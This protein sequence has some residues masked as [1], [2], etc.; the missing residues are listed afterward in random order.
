MIDLNLKLSNSLSSL[1]LDLVHQLIFSSFEVRFSFSSASLS[2][3]T[4]GANSLRM[5]REGYGSLFVCVRIT[6]LQATPFKIHESTIKQTW[7]IGNGNGRRNT[8]VQC[9]QMYIAL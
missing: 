7:A 9:V 1:P 6:K 4:A 3:I 2:V 8:A 5:Y